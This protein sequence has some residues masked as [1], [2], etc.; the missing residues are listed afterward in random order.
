MNGLFDG[1][2]VEGVLV[3]VEVLRKLLRITLYFSEL[4]C[5]GISDGVNFD[6]DVV[7]IFF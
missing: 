6:I 1:R 4:E 7:D 2:Q 3:D 5:N